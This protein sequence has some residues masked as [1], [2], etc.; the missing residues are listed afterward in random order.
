MSVNEICTFV[1]LFF[2][3]VGQ[4]C[5]ETVLPECTNTT[6]LN[7]GNC[8]VTNESISCE[9]QTGWTGENCESMYDPCDTHLCYNNGTCN[10]TDDG[11]ATCVCE[12][13]WSGDNCETEFNPCG[14]GCMN[15]GTCVSESGFPNNNASLFL[16]ACTENYT[17]VYCETKLTTTST[18]VSPTTQETKSKS[19]ISWYE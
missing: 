1:R 9:C 18:A 2:I 14:D 13:G 7:G 3:F 15:N 12:E 10:S 11:T 16:C 4:F 17:G 5:N 19:E 6:C 8:S